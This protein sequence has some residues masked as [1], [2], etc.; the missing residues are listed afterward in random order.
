MAFWPVREEPAP[1]EAAP[2]T[3]YPSEYLVD[4]EESEEEGPSAEEGEAER[5]DEVVLVDD[6]GESLVPLGE[7]EGPESGAPPDEG[8]DRAR[9]RHR[10]RR[11]TPAGSEEGTGRS[12]CDESWASAQS[13]Q[14]SGPRT[15]RGTG[16]L[17]G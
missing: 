14:V 10:Q 3:E 5:G 12:R 2:P 15:P 7:E 1:E 4:L 8:P 9:R 16:R 13:R 11:R 17:P 6:T